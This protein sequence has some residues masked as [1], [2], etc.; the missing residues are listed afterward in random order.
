MSGA[1]ANVEA[2]V[3]AGGIGSRLAG[4]L[5]GIPKVLAPIEGRPFLDYQL[6]YLAGE[7][8][9]RVV[10]S[11]GYRAELVLEHLAH[12]KLPLKVDT[13]VE[14]RPLGTAGAI[15]FA[16]PTLSSD[17]VLLLNGDTWL[18]IDLA[19]M[20]ETHRTPPVPL[21][22]IACVRVDDTRRYGSV[23][24]AAGGSVA[25]FLEK[26]EASSGGGLVNG[27]VYVL[28]AHLLDSLTVAGGSSLE[29]DV[30]PHL[31]AGTLRAHLTG[32]ANFLDI[33]TPASYALAAAH[34]S[35]RTTKPLAEGGA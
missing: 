17:P 4:V 10:L 26:D 14:P 3:L 18:D 15:A 25:R 35:I 23:E 13:V 5:G 7:G 16:R 22:T 29:R 24:L 20:L 33:G 9:S 30:L 32:P 28:S 12:T 11:L 1:P 27:G 19:E 6:E 31:G 21:A 2:L 8:V 34:L